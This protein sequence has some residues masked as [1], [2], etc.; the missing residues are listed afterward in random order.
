M[1]HLAEF[2]QGGG[3]DTLSWGIGGNQFRVRPFQVGQFSEQPIILSI[4]N[5]RVVLDVI[6]VVMMPDLALELG[7]SL[8]LGGSGFRRGQRADE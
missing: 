6:E 5:L 8:L 1:L 2:I 4:G 3:T 7:E